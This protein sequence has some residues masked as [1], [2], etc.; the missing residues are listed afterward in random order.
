MLSCG[1]YL[2]MVHGFL[3]NISFFGAC[4][5]IGHAFLCVIHFNEHA[6][7]WDMPSCANYHDDDDGDDND[8]DDDINC[9]KL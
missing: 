6:F 4:L 7:L 8:D 5:S 9:I 2:F 1:A 3:Q